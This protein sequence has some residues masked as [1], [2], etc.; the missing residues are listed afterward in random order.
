MDRIHTRPQLRR[1]IIALWLLA[2]LL[3]IAPPGM[4]QGQCGFAE[5]PIDPVDTTV[6]QLVQDFGVPSSR[7]QGRYHTGEDW[8]AGHS[9]GDFGIGAPVRAIATGRV[10]Y[11]STIGW[12]RDGGVVII[13]HTM[14]DGSLAYSQYGHIVEPPD[15]SFPPVWSC[16]QQG[17]IIGAIG[18]VRP[19][20]HLHF[21]IRVRDG[22]APGPGYSWEN[23]V[24]AGWRRPRKFLRNWQTWLLPAYQWRVELTDE[25]GPVT[26]PLRLDD[27]SLIYL[28]AR[29]VLR[30]SPDGRVLWRVLLDQPA[31]GLT[32]SGDQAVIVF[33]SGMMQVINRD[34]TLGERWETGLTPAGAPVT[35]GDLALLPLAGDALAALD[36]TRQAVMWQADNVPPLVRSHD[37]GALIGLITD[38]NR[39][40]VFSPGGALLNQSYLREP[41]SLASDV[42][43]GLLAYTRG[44]L[45]R[46]QP[47]ATWALPLAGAPPGGR[48]SALARAPEGDLYLF[49]GAVLHV[50]DRVGALAWQVAIPGISGLVELY[51]YGAALLLLSTHG[52]IM[53]L[54]KPGG[55]ICGS[56][57][58]YGDDHA[59]LWH[60]L[61]DDGVLRVAVSDQVI[62]L[63][64]R[65][66][67]GGCAR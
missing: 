45:W 14:P 8:F 2:A 39:L 44:G 31:V 6:F 47:D 53:A 4:A 67:L 1:F 24:S 10:T 37:S 9:A 16:V 29:R 35:A 21:E 38:D 18:D 50:Y 23:P 63:D 56:A 13:E 40:L 11:A 48:A 58:I 60:H 20:P 12:G 42:D 46:I 33:A 49:D 52:H 57:H 65:R 27:N 26:P 51:D 66:L 59:R 61:G 15:G 34:G 3:G 17:A 30:I 25:F 5:S 28:D 55:G 32:T 7:H 62:G 54:Q 36:A 64:W 41:G 43:G 19:A 22:T